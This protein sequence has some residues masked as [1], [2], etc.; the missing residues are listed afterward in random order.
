MK[1]KN[2]RDNLIKTAI[3]LFAKNG[4]A[5]TS[6]RAIGSKAGISTSVLYHYFNNKQEILFEVINASSIELSQELTKIKT[7][8]SDPLE[9]LRQMLMTHMVHFSL[10]RNEETKIMA[11]DSHFLQGEN[12]LAIRKILS[13]IYEIYNAQLKA[14]AEKG[15]INDVDL[16]V[17]VFSI[18][19]LISSFYSWYREN[20]RLSKEEI[21]Q[22]IMDILSY[23]IFKHKK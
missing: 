1:Q 5:D 17:V 10:K 21:A 11:S 15:L 13:E 4:Y 19:G 7:Q 20:G 23:G 8:Y 22:N 6:I 12:R 9:C 2:T 14:I 16:T 3:S 18:F